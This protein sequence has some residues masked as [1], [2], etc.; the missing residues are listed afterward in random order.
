MNRKITSLRLQRNRRRVTVQLDDGSALT[1]APILAAPL[2]AGQ[3]LDAAQA[4]RLQREDLLEDSF[5]RAL[6]LI[7]RRARSRAE[8]AQYLRRR[9]VDE[10]EAGAVIERLTQRGYLNDAE[11][12]RAWVE[13]RQAF[14]PRSRRA[15]QAEL[16]RL[17]VAEADVRP[18]LEN[19]PEREAALA[20]ARKRA[21][22][23]APA[24]GPDGRTARMDF[25]QKLIAFLAMRGFDYELARE[26][27]RQVWEET[28]N[29]AS[30]EKESEA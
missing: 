26:T 12:A 6:G 1:L 5:Q 3:E 16:R 4:E 17:G 20:A 30:T 19:L 10:A 13:N 22:R 23:K 27:A 25:E 11:F 14:R 21:A 18:A 28:H 7:A 2:K 29:A 15:L 24:A 8:I 9:K